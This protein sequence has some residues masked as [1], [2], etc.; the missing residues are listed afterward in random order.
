MSTLQNLI[1]KQIIISRLVIVSGRKQSFATTTGTLAEIQP[2][3]PAKTQLVEGVMGKTFACYTN[4]TDD[5]QEGD[6]IRE[7]N[8]GNKYRVRTGGVSRRTFGSVD[9]LAIIMEQIN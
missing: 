3:S 8:T 4:P 6:Q 5:I 1:T 7:V 2:L 9:F